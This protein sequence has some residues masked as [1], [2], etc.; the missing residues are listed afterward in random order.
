[1]RSNNHIPAKLAQAYSNGFWQP[2]AFTW[3]SYEGEQAVPEGEVKTAGKSWTCQC[4]LNECIME[5][6]YCHTC[7]RELERAFWSR[8]PNFPNLKS[9]LQTYPCKLTS[10]FL[11]FSLPLSTGELHPFPHPYLALLLWG[12]EWVMKKSNAGQRVMERLSLTVQHLKFYL[13]IAPSTI[14]K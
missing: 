1:M 4:P 12:W 6:F 10:S 5:S 7:F 14:K 13:A 8:I 2:E 9:F 3:T 11:L